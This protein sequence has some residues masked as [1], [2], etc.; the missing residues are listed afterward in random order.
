MMVNGLFLDPQ[1]DLFELLGRLRKEVRKHFLLYI[2]D[3]AITP[4]PFSILQSIMNLGSALGSVGRGPEGESAGG[5]PVTSPARPQSQ[6]WR[7]RLERPEAR[8]LHL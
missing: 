7:A 4:Q 5:Q 1:S 6:S 8:P 3:Q 2:R